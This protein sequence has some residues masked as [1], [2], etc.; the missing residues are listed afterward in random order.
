[1]RARVVRA[2]QRPGGGDGLDERGRDIVAAATTAATSASES[3]APVAPSVSI[4]AQTGQIARQLHEA[5]VQ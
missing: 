3:N 5:S 1:M 4:P 2:L